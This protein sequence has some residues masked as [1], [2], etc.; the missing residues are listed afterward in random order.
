MESMPVLIEKGINSGNY[1]II[2][3]TAPQKIDAEML[4]NAYVKFY[5][6][7]TT[8]DYTYLKDDSGFPYFEIYQEFLTTRKKD[9]TIE[10]YWGIGEVQIYT[11]SFDIEVN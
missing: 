11:L 3:L 8:Y 6:S 4:K 2:N 1:L 10:L 9:F 7:G 5:Y